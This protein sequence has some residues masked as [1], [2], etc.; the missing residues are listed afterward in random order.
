M[1]VI[2]RI[3]SLLKEII[4]TVIA[5]NLMVII[6]FNFINKIVYNNV[7]RNAE[8]Y[9]ETSAQILEQYLITHPTDVLNKF[10][11]ELKDMIYD[12]AT[13]NDVQ[14]YLNNLSRYIFHYQDSDIIYS[15]LF[16]YFVTLEEYSV[17]LESFLWK[18]GDY[19][20]YERPWFLNTKDTDGKIISTLNYFDIVNDNQ[21][22][23]Y[24]RELFDKNGV[25][26]GMAGM[27]IPINFL[28]NRILDLQ[29]CTSGYGVLLSEELKFIIHPHDDFKEAI[30]CCIDDNN[31]YFL[32]NS[33]SGNIY[34]FIVN[35]YVSHRNEKS[36][37]FIKKL[38]NDWFLGISANRSLFYNDGLMLFLILGICG[39]IFALFLIFILMT[40]YDGKVKSDLKNYHKSLFLA[41]LSH[42]IRTPIN[43]IMGMSSMGI[44]SCD[45]TKKDYCF[46]K[47]NNASKHILELI[48]DV[49]DLSKIEANK[50]EL[51]LGEFNYKNMIQ[52]IHNLYKEKISEKQQEFNVITDEN[53]PSALIGD[54]L[55][56]SQVIINLISNA[57][58]FTP[59]KGKISLI[60]KLL[61]KDNNICAIQISVIDSGIG[62][63]S[64][65][66]GKLFKSY[67]QAEKDISNK[68]GGTGLGLSISKH[69]VEMMGGIIW[70]E[71]EIEKGSSFIFIVKMKES[72]NTKIIEN[73]LNPSIKLN[74]QNYCI[75][76]AEDIDINAEIINFLL[77]PTK[78]K[79]E[80]AKDGIEVIKMF[81]E[82]P[83]RYDL[84]LMD[85][86]MPEMN[87]ID[88]TRAIRSLDIEKAKT[89][90]I[91]AMTASALSSDIKD[92]ISSGMNDHMGKPVEITE[93]YEKLKFYLEKKND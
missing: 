44:T 4:F 57:I 27:R 81:S 16:G 83:D 41:N 75:L 17:H 68:F 12:G 66:M 6:S 37:L 23:I 33:D 92:C 85:I 54:E 88:A 58:K 21:T 77:E 84:I 80:V 30:L 91:L 31:R 89:I 79:L 7:V 36:I 8:Y 67:Q 19:N 52:K 34:N 47:I 10:S 48:N 2:K 26:L 62:L 39:T 35:N 71:S 53:I 86:Q 65:Q 11:I 14:N 18:R 51:I 63:T 64:E 70:V 9:L 1:N 15:E 45:V 59:E 78:V 55:R 46:E 13:T 76:L 32:I 22:L 69:I 25:Y 90:P 72:N 38:S 93:M 73:K 42:E 61:S 74:L 87:G 29:L 3:K 5:F 24:S 20:I 43:I 60:S 28:E 40:I 49:L 50:L 82:N 56:L